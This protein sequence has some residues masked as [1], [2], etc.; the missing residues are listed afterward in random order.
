MDTDAFTRLQRA[1]SRPLHD[2]ILNRTATVG[3]V[4]LGYVGLPLLTAASAEGFP[5]IGLDS[6]ARRVGSLLAGQSYV[7]DILDQ[8][9]AALGPAQFTTYPGTTE[10]IV[11]PVLETSGL[12]AGRDFHLGYS[13]ERIDPGRSH[14][15]RDTPKI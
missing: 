2:A 1:P 5:V 3:I 6:D 9:L 8:D 7:V 11:R 15:F 13:P 4:G 12:E 10:E 14:N